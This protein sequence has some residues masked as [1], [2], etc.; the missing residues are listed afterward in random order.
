MLTK[1]LNSLK[2]LQRLTRLSLGGCHMQVRISWSLRR[3]K[4]SNSARP[5]SPERRLA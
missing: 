2:A 5:L 1:C 3:A 4:D